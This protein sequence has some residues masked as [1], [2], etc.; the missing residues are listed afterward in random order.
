MWNRINLRTRIHALL[1]ALIFITLAGGLVMVWYTYQMQGLINYIAERN[2]AALHA[3][4]ELEIAL[5]SQKGFVSY[6]FLDGDPNWLKQLEEYR[7]IFKSRLHEAYQRTE[8]PQQREA[9]DKIESE[10]KQYVASKDRV[11]SY[12]R[13][14]SR[15]LG[16]EL[17][18][19]VRQRFFKI[20][21]LTN[22]FKRIQINQ[23]TQANEKSRIQAE[24]LR[25]IAVTAML[26]VFL[27]GGLLAFVLTSQVLGPVRRLA[28]KADREGAPLKP[29]NEIKALS[30]GV[31][32][33]MDDIDHSR[34]ELEKSQQVLLQAEKMA[35]VGKLAAG[36]AHSIR[37]PLTSVKMR[38]F[39]LA[40]SLDLNKDQ[41]E[42][43]EVISGEIAHINTIVENFLEF[44]RP[45]KLKMQ[46]VCPSDVVDLS[47]KLLRHR[48][49]S[50][51]VSI[52]LEREGPVPDI[53]ADPE[54]FKEALLNIL[55]NACEAM[56]GG[57]ILTIHEEKGPSGPFEKTVVIRLSDNGPGIPE[58]IHD[59]VFQ[60][61]FTTKD[62]GTGLGLCIAARI[63]EQ[64]GG[65]LDLT[66]KE[67]E[68]AAFVINLPI[69][70][71][72]I[73]QNP[74]H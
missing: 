21:E 33:L 71:S 14:G 11:I 10:Y 26:A 40:R 8:T 38:L 63:I 2:V 34:S 20:L 39:S 69:L 51:H 15:E 59:K 65:S 30:R 68:G 17:H 16:A 31:R 13:E 4:E 72:S 73:A 58:S 61:F 1:I 29:M 35:L 22:D 67:G 64:H 43:F 28:M 37:N 54:Q 3:A 23:I 44:S 52:K 32:G 42:D 49:E 25:I 46:R 74:D 45:P 5:V 27:L 70:E 55:I 19:N 24:R 7:Q 53:E 66:S 56:K 9:I 6:Y 60:P 50:H 36:T 12:Y 47:I 41:K 18:K 57:G 48:L 62:Q